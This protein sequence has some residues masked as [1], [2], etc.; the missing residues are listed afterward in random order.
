MLYHDEPATESK[1][2]R[3][4][5]WE[6][7]IDKY[8]SRGEMWNISDAEDA[9]RELQEYT[10]YDVP[11]NISREQLVTC[12]DH[13]ARVAIALCG[14]E[15]LAYVTKKLIIAIEALRLENKINH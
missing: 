13:V 15:N 8:R 10:V 12:L 4:R 9:L 6:G 1:L 14:K 7:L 5:I 2:E 11:G 3:E